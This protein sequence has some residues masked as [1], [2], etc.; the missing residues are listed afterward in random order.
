MPSVLRSKSSGTFIKPFFQR[1]NENPCALDGF[2]FN[3]GKLLMGPTA[4]GNPNTFDI[5]QNMRDID[6]KIQG[7]MFTYPAL[8]TWGI[9]YNQLSVRSSLM[10][11]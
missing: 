6:R 5:E 7:K 4:N 1:E 8:K 2:K 10:L 11:I 3:A 9:F